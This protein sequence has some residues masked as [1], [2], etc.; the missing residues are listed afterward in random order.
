MCRRAQTLRLVTACPEQLWC[1]RAGIDVTASDAQQP[2]LAHSALEG[3]RLAFAAAVGPGLAPPKCLSMCVEQH[4]AV[5]LPREADAVDCLQRN[6]CRT[7]IVQRAGGRCP[8]PRW[9]LFGP[10]FVGT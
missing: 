3:V 8:P 10:A 9:I 5:H 2:L 7:Q 6:T 1:R 4:Q